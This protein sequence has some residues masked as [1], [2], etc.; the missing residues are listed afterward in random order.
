MNFYNRQDEFYCGIDLHANS[1]HVCVVDHQGQ[2]QLHRDLNTKKIE[3]FLGAM[4]PLE[5]SFVRGTSLT[6]SSCVRKLPQTPFSPMEVALHLNHLF[7]T[8]NGLA[9]R[10]PRRSLQT[11]CV[12]HCSGRS[13]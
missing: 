2:K 5:Q 10:L 7:A 12:C 11:T 4:Q 9:K 3:R 13:Y 6:I 1:M 8:P